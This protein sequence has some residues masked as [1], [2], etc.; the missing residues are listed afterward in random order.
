[1]FR[2]WVSFSLYI[3]VVSLLLKSIAFLIS[4]HAD[5]LP[6]FILPSGFLEEGDVDV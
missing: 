5:P 4:L 2:R 3:L 1:M 6:E